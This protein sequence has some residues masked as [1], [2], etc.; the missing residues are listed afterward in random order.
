MLKLA[1]RDIALNRPKGLAVQLA[2]ELSERIARGDLK[3]GDRLPSEHELTAT[4]GISRTVVREAI[5]SLKADG[6]VASQQGVGV[7]V[8]QASASV[9]FRIN[10]A[11]LGAVKEVLRLLELR[12]SLE[13]EAAALAAMR[14]TDEQLGKMSEALELMSRS[15][16]AGDDAIGPD[17]QFH[18]EV[19]KATDNHYFEDLFNYLGTMAIPRTRV[20]IYQ[21]DAAARSAYLQDVNREHHSILQAIRNRDPEAARAAMRMHLTNSRERRRLAYE[22]MTAAQ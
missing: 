4:Y 15:I 18:M 9:P 2:E 10:Q 3:P 12:I 5:S 19:A 7:F 8:L 13:T 1:R 21:T 11:D 20:G 6:L 14:R 17:F 22:K 16:E